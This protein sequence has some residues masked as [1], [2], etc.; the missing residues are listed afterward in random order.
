MNENIHCKVTIQVWNP[1]AC[2][3]QIGGI[4][5]QV[6]INTLVEEST[7]DS[8]PLVY[9]A[10]LGMLPPVEGSTMEEAEWE[11]SNIPGG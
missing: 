2:C 3:V 7:G 6:G 1:V 5:F 9:A 11:I 10:G 4:F 8:D